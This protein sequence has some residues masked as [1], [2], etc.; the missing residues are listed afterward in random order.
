MHGAV[1]V[2]GVNCG[3]AEHRQGTHLAGRV[4]K[5]PGQR[6]R[7][8]GVLG[9]LGDPPQVQQGYRPADQAVNH[10]PVRAPVPHG[11]DDRGEMAQRPGQISRVKCHVP[12]PELRGAPLLAARRGTPGRVAQ[13]RVLTY[14]PAAQGP[15]RRQ[16]DRQPQ[17]GGRIMP[18]GPGQHLPHRGVLSIQ[19]PCSG[20]LSDGGL[21]SPRGL[22]G[23]TQCVPGQGGRRCLLLPGLSEQPGTVGAQRLQQHIPGPAIW[24]GPRRAKQRTVHQMQHRRPGARSRHRLGGIQR[25]RP[26][27]HRQR[28]EHPP[29]LVIEQLVT[30]GHRGRQRPLPSRRQPVTSGQQNEPVIEAVQQLRHP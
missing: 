13:Q 12:E 15:P 1:E 20:C 6:Q 8:V 24:A 2:A 5:L 19:P 9:R 28:A 23:H 4:A 30:P 25:E 26:R 14:G 22:F 7:T 11:V 3:E 27:E 29:L 21:Q 16:R 18:G 10:R 17:R